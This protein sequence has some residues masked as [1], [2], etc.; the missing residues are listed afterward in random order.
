M[1]PALLMRTLRSGCSVISLGRGGVD[2]G[3]VG[4]IELDRRHAGVRCDDLIEVGAAAPGNDHHVAESLWNASASARP[5]P[6]VLA[7]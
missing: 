5:M 4:N 1:M 2:A 3:G 7:P 6:D